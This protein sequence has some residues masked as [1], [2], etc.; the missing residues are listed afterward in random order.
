MDPGANWPARLAAPG[1]LQVQQETAVIQKTESDHRRSPR[2]AS[3]LYKHM[4]RH[5]HM[6]PYMFKHAY[7]DMPETI[8]CRSGVFDT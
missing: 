5:T 7:T 8:R 1:Q 4:H 3:D 2:S 6:H